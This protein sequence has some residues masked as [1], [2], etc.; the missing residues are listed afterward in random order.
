MENNTHI[1]TDLM[2]FLGIPGGSIIVDLGLNL[3]LVHMTA[4]PPWADTPEKVYE[5]VRKFTDEIEKHDKLEILLSGE[6]LDNIISKNKTA[7][8]LGLQHVPKDACMASLRG[9]GISIVIP[10]YKSWK[11]HAGLTDEGRQFMIN[12]DELG[13]C[14]DISHTNHETAKDILDFAKAMEIKIPVIASHTGC[15]SIYPIERNLPDE[16][17]K[18][19]ADQGGIV[20]IY[21]MSFF[22]EKNDKSLDPMFRHIVK[23]MDICGSDNVCIGSDIAYLERDEEEWKD[24]FKKLQ[25]MLDSDGKMGSSWP[26]YPKE[27]NCIDKEYV[28][29]KKFFADYRFLSEDIPGKLF[30]K[31]FWNFAKRYL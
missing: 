2:G 18:Q 28:L 16:V 5:E 7:V 8:V 22:L 14:I 4:A 27:L 20:G 23:A 29:A 1:T 19:I 12:C 31:N 24:D 11:N 3:D 25:A 9:F 6:N 26:D 15:Y 17:L 21:A 10:S 13:I 30:G